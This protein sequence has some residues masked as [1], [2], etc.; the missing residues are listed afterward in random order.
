[1]SFKV[2]KKQQRENYEFMLEEKVDKDTIDKALASNELTLDEK[3]KLLKYYYQI[4][5][6]ITDSFGNKRINVC[7]YKS[8]E[9]CEYQTRYF[10]K[11]C[12]SLQN[13]EKKIRNTIAKDI[14][15]DI[16]ICN[17][18]PSLIYQYTI[19]N[20]FLNMEDWSKDNHNVLRSY[21][22]KR[23][24]WLDK[25]MSVHK[26]NRDQAKQMITSMTN[27]GSYSYIND[28]GDTIFVD[29]KKQLNTVNRY[30]EAIKKVIDIIS[31]RIEYKR[32]AEIKESGKSK[33]PG[34]TLLSSIIYGIESQCVRSMIDFFEEKKYRVGVYCF[35]GIMVEKQ[36]TE[37]N[38]ITD[39]LL[40]KCVNYIKIQT[41]YKIKI[42]N[43]PM[44]GGITLPKFTSFNISDEAAAQKIVD[45]YEGDF[46]YS[47]EVKK[48]YT[49]NRDSGMW[50]HT[51]EVLINYKMEK[52]KNFLLVEPKEGMRYNYK[53]IKSYGSFDKI[54]KT[55]IR[56]IP[57]KAMDD[58]WFNDSIDTSKEKLLYRNGIY[59]LA[60]GIFTKK[61]D[62]N[63][64]FFHKIERNYKPRNQ[65]NID[66]V[67]KYLFDR[68]KCKREYIDALIQRLAISISSNITKKEVMF[69]PG[70]TNGG[71]STLIDI[72]KRCFNGYVSTFNINDLCDNIGN[73]TDKSLKLK[74]AYNNATRR[75]LFSS[76]SKEN[77]PKLDSSVL[78][79]FSSGG[80]DEITCRGLFKDEITVIPHFTI[81]IVANNLPEMDKCDEAMLRRAQ[82][83][84]YDWSYTS[85]EKYDK[86]VE[87]QKNMPDVDL[88]LN[89]YIVTDSD[90][91]DII[92]KK[93]EF[94]EGFEHILFDAY[95][96]YINGVERND[97]S[98]MNNLVNQSR[99]II[100]DEKIELLSD[101]FNNTKD[102]LRYENKIITENKIFAPKG[103]LF[104]FDVELK[105]IWLDD[106]ESSDMKTAKLISE[107]FIITKDNND[108]IQAS[109]F[110]KI[111]SLLDKKKVLPDSKAKF[112][113]KFIQSCPHSH[114]A[115]FDAY[116]G[117]KVNP[118]NKY[119]D[120]QNGEFIDKT[121]IDCI[122]DF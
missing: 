106:G 62:K 2:S 69:L 111:V 32:Y 55:A 10:A 15:D 40:E 89:N 27:G 79:M 108:F 94:I 80:K 43:K 48:L 70:M 38:K 116:L 42:I 60:T 21:V 34:A 85:Q 78:K 11:N 8:N 72:L 44:T 117:C 18:G 51:D 7:Y 50:D 36:K 31:L 26:I 101:D 17:C 28:N 65:N 119:F 110:Q 67:N 113:T 49:Y 88:G 5:N 107:L 23:E 45:C 71:K 73:N 121:S 52:I 86:L 103:K 97:I 4:E 120:I 91:F 3:N 83:F 109:H 75:I 19:K 33:N 47:G 12:I 56:C 39:E 96:L 20:N 59:N 57:Q 84:S 29:E 66:L 30:R 68:Y 9:N 53:D 74:F 61:F 24:E 41:G 114:K 76:E 46:K 63:I 16:D 13:M 87:T 58:N 6:A 35:D 104:D 25:I 92:S 81:W 22:K 14:Y 1:M 64:V 98:I 105:N 82:Y 37:S 95:F 118:K 54:R 112:K 102:I 90:E 99:N 77:S 93:I 100:P 115:K 122:I